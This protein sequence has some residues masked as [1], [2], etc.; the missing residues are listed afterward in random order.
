MYVKENRREIYMGWKT[1]IKQEP[2][3]LILSLHQ[4]SSSQESELYY[5]EA[6]SND[7]DDMI[8]SDIS[9]NELVSSLSTAWMLTWNFS[10]KP[11]CHSVTEHTENVSKIT[12]HSGICSCIVNCSL[13]NWSNA[14]SMWIKWLNCVLS[15]SFDSKSLPP[16]EWRKVPFRLLQD[17][18]TNLFS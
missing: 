15:C 13:C 5:Q 3:A 7:T 11:L 14:E 10:P 1:T 8:G 12:T 18:I 2:C 17:Q 9:S 16:K 4:V 6:Y